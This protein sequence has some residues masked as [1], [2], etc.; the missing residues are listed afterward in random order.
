M[1]VSLPP[2]QEEFV[3]VQVASGRYRS[4]SEVLREGLRLLERE[5]HRRLVEQ[6]VFGDLSEDEAAARLPAEVVER[7]REHF[8][9]LVDEGL[10]SA[11]GK[12]WVTRE[13]LLVQLGRSEDSLRDAG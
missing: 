11:E 2:A 3:R 6:W 1:N 4:A 10:R 9:K 12:G 7:V 5:E 8:Q 13:E